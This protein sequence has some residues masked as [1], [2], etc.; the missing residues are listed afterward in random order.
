[1]FRAR[2]IEPRSAK[3]F[4]SEAIARLFGWWPRLGGSNSAKV[5]SIE[6]TERIRATDFAFYHRMHHALEGTFGEIQWFRY[7][8]Q[9]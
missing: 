7:A 5:G 9:G 1:M 6:C 2:L 8:V 4:S 3:D